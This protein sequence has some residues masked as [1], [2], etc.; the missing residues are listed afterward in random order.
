[1]VTVSEGGIKEASMMQRSG[2]P[3]LVVSQA[4][5]IDSVATT[6]GPGPASLA[7][8]AVAMLMPQQS[9]SVTKLLVVWY[10]A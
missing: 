8:A 6:P 10:H 3:T 1:M 2:S 4:H 9:H 5:H 7:G